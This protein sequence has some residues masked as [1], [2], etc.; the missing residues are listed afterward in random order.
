MG[1]GGEQAFVVFGFADGG[2]DA[3]E[4][5]QPRYCV[6]QRERTYNQAANNVYFYWRFW[7]TVRHVWFVPIPV[8]HLTYG[9][10]RTW[11]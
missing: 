7:V 5:V 11:G 3:V 4:A 10:A 9:G 8:P 6:N 2:G 1:D